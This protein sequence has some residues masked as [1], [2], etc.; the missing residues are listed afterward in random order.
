[1]QWSEITKELNQ[2][3]SKKKFIEQE[4][5]KQVDELLTRLSKVKI[6]DAPVLLKL[7]ELYR[8]RPEN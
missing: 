7:Y 5:F 3:P 1:M 6:I 8:Y 2:N 4:R